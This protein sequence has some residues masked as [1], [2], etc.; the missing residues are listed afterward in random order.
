MVV[1]HEIAELEDERES[2]L[3]KIYQNKEKIKQL[4]NLFL[5]EI[6]SCNE[7]LIDNPELLNTLEDINL[8]INSSY[9][10]LEPSIKS[11]SIKNQTREEYKSVSKR[12]ALFYMS[13]N[14]LKVIDQL[15][16]FSIGSFFKLFSNSIT[17][18]NKSQ[19]R[20]KRISNI[21]DQLNN[22]VFE[23]SCISIYEK[24]NLLFLFQIACSL[25][26]D[27]GK[28]L[29][30]ELTF[31]IKG[32]IGSEPIQ[33]HTEEVNIENPTTWLSNKCWQ[34]VVNLS[35][36]FE[37]FYNLIEHVRCNL[38]DWEKVIFRLKYKLLFLLLIDCCII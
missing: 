17:S 34:N 25:D 21:I 9:A 18:A 2:L 38:D 24:H 32:D 5:V 8:K 13:L 29:D 11:L 1:K 35:T 3:E 4:K 23:F 7:P 15:Y 31:F 20:L 27:A 28:L 36:S 33:K 6:T 26:K 14:E 19:I 30:S 22:T 10:E 16:Q 12:G 37:H